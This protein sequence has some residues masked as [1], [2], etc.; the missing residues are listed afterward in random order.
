MEYGPDKESTLA[1]ALL[2]ESCIDTD[3]TTEDVADAIARAIIGRRGS[4]IGHLELLLTL[5]CNHRCDYCFV[6]G[7]GQVNDMPLS[8]AKQA[9][10]FLIT[11]SGGLGNVHILPFGGEPL[12]R[13]DLV[14]EV[15]EYAKERA[16]TRVP[17]KAVSFSFTT[18]GT[19]LDEEKMAFFQ[20]HGIMVLLS[21]D[22]D[23]ETHDRHRRMAN[24]GSSYET[25]VENLPMIRYYQPWLGTRMTVHPD[26]IKEMARNFE[27]LVSL[28]INQF[29]IGPATGIP[30][31][32]EQWAD[33]ESESQMIR[34]L[35]RFAELRPSMPLRINMFE[36]NIESVPGRQKGLWGCGAGKGRI[37]VAADGSL[38]PCS[39]VVGVDGLGQTHRLGD[40]WA[41]IS[42]YSKRGQLFTAGE[43]ERLKCR[44]CEFKDDC[45]GGCPAT[46]Y[47]ETGSLFAPSWLDC[48]QT[49]LMVRL[50]QEMEECGS[51]GL[52][53]A[54]LKHI[55]P[56]A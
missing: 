12:L 28:G 5:N 19:L 11:A 17:P 53:P 16:R 21:L 44:E 45:T 55:R 7:K 10:D 40:V 41:G 23:R 47:E 32:I 36:R 39:K 8:V 33:Y 52:P 34:I 51:L 49:R 14:R 56:V 6:H 20:R 9:V 18:N 1:P 46:N 15:V 27:H 29:I 50:R 37:A 54:A 22:G 2:S 43:D 4:P 25:V 35:H 42:E 3:K 13:F 24:G 31:T 30:W 26:A 38:Y 48:M